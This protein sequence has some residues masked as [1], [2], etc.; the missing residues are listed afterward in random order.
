MSNCLIFAQGQTATLTAQFVTSPAG[1]A[2]NVPDAKVSIWGPGGA[3]ILPPVDMVQVA[4]LIGFYYLDWPIPNSLPVD[5][6]TVRYTGTVMGTPTAATEYL[7]V[8]LAGT[9]TS[10][11]FTQRKVELLAALE[12]YIG[13]AQFIPV[14]QDLAR[15]NASRDVYNFT[16][17]RWNLSN[18][19]IM[20]NDEIVNSGY[21]LDL[22]TATVTFSRPLHDTDA[23]HGSYNFRF[24]TDID[25]LGFMSDALGQINLEPPGTNF[26]LDTVPDSYV[27]VLMLGANKN[28]MKRLIFC[29]SL[30]EPST[31]FGGPDRVKDAIS[32]FKDLKDNNE[33]EF[34]RDKKQIKRAVYPRMAMVATPTYTLPG[35]RSRWFRYLF[36]SGMS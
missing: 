33:K 32:N 16:W 7:S 13:C 31:I 28:V 30:Q 14:Y 10:V 21:T 5:T 15:R 18:H 34:E 36:S 11:T 25:L 12:K 2:V 4:G 24:F 35:G 19:I 6:Y 3:A 22:D 23:V 9:P 20:V 29:L 17:P 1:M 26:N 27:G 8:V